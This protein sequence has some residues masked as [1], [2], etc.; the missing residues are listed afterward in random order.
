MGLTQ[1]VHGTATVEALLALGLARGYVGRPKNGLM[2]IRGHSG[3]QGGGE[4]GAYANVYPGVVSIDDA[5]ADALE[6]VWGFRPPA[7]VGLDSVQMLEAADAG[8][9]D[10]FYCIGGNLRDT[11]PDPRRVE[12]ALAK[13]PCRIHQDIVLTH[14]MLVPP[15]DVVYLLPARTRYESRG[16]IT[17]TTTERRVVFSPYID[18]HDIGESREEW[19]I[20]RALLGA[21][22]PERLA[23]LGFDDAA[24][25]RADIAKTVPFY[26][27][28]ETLAK[29]GDAFQWGGERL[30]EGGVF[31][32]AGGRAAFFVNPLPERVRAPDELWLST[33]RGKQFN[34]MVH[35]DFDPLTGASRDHVFMS[36]ADMRERDLAQDTPILVT[37][38]VGRFEGRAFGAPI[39]TGNVQMFWPEANPLL[40]SGRVDPRGKVPDYNALVRI[41]R[42]P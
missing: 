34:S 36:E 27:G 24:S 35:A 12:R 17:E 8:A 33:R 3:V 42:R 11:L 23:S 30:C 5:S 31:P 41:E 4:M 9:L 19:W 18:G 7:R 6:K 25:I 16:G 13:I 37:S 32:R 39:A 21:A 40:P 2:P 28:I 29:Q 26:A 1:H 10:V 38:A 20:A 14:A 15:D 22:Y